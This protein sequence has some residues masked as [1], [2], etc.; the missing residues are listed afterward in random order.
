MKEME[1]LQQEKQNVHA[2]KER[3]ETELNKKEE[4]LRIE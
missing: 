1:M 4:M 3:V 2:D